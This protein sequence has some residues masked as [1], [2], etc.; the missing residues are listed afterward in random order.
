MSMEA[1]LAKRVQWLGAGSRRYLWFD[2]SDCNREEGYALQAAFQREIV[3]QDGVD[4]LILADFESAYHDSA[5]TGRWKDAYA[6]HDAKVAKIACLGVVG[7]MKIVFAAHRFFVRLRGV[8]VDQKMRLFDDK[9][10][11]L[12]WLLEGPSF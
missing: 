4:L 10:Q 6:E 3:E 1:S 8:D 7:S 12:V 2:C 5:L 9:E 11:A